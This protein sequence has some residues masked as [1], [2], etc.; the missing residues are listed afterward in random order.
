MSV[1]LDDPAFS[2]DPNH[3]PDHAF[4]A[5]PKKD[6]GSATKANF[7]VVNG[8][9][10]ETDE[11][12]EPPPYQFIDHPETIYPK[13][14]RDESSGTTSTSSDAWYEATARNIDDTDTMMN[15]QTAEVDP[16]YA[17]ESYDDDDDTQLS[18]LQDDE[19]P[20]LSSSRSNYVSPPS[21][22]VERPV[23]DVVQAPMVTNRA[24]S[25]PSPVLLLERPYI[26][27]RGA[28][29]PRVNKSSTVELDRID[30]LDESVLL[31]PAM[32]HR[33]PYEMNGKVLAA[34]TRIL[35]YQRDQQVRR[36]F[37]SSVEYLG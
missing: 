21:R 15:R 20:M 14:P 11:G 2:Q 36:L 19:S 23:Q 13:H 31:G 9:A 28:T 26:P 34:P 27:R 22:V 12:D 17:T 1:P 5:S 16:Y 24:I 7:A 33:G 37:L 30:E 29:T 18:Y 8:A 10:N 4:Y 3:H 25:E 35:P 32:H 6:G